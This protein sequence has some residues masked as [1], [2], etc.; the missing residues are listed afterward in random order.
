MKLNKSLLGW[1][2]YD[3]ANSSFTTVIVTV[4]YSVYFKKV[5]VGQ[6]EYGTS[7]WGIAIS[8][9]MLIVA[10]SSP[11]LG[12]IADYS[13]SKKKFL[14]IYCYSAVVFTGLLY[15]VRSGHILSGMLFFIIANIGFEG[16]NVFYNAFLPEIAK[17][18]D[19]G[20]VSGLGWGIGY[21]GGLLSLLLVYPFAESK[22]ILVFPIIALFYGIFAI[23]TF[24]FVSEKKLIGKYA[25]NYIKQGY[26]RIKSTFQHLNKFKELGKFLI[27]FFIYN[28]GIKTVIV[29]S[30]I[31]GAKTFDMNVNQL[32]IYFVLAQTSSF[33]GAIVFG[34]TMDKIGAKNTISLTLLIWLAVVIWAFFCPN[35][36]QFYGIGLL[37]GLAMGSSQSSSRSMLSLLTPKNK[38]AEFFGFYAFTG[39][40]SAILGPFI[41]GQ[42]AFFSGNQR[43]AILSI[44]F[45]F[46]L[47]LTVLQ[48]VNETEGR[49][50]ARCVG[51]NA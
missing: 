34:Y 40:A 10:I 39:K 37:A 30:A 35:I 46:I 24:V 6:E 20:K 18:K 31:Y 45:F 11:V 36:K 28:D 42:I 15:F 2:S 33:I 51:R 43:F 27:A 47:G 9:S 48:F 3:F 29:F 32:I 49:E 44:A 4:V 25:T 1:I 21:L 41:Y 38:Q 8:I 14:F 7:L 19:I 16:G 50:L 12:A 23:P 5:V 13:H 26:N 22:T 17:E